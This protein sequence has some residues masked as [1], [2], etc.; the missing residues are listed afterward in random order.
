MKKRCYNC[1][2]SRYNRYGGRGIRVADCWLHDYHAFKD[3]AIS[4][5]YKKGL[6]IERIDND[7]N[8][9][10]DNC[11]WIPKNEQSKNRSMNIQVSLDGDNL[12]LKDACRKVGIIEHYA[13]IKDR[14]LIKGMS[15]KEAISVP[16]KDFKSKDIKGV[17]F[18]RLVALGFHHKSNRKEYWLCQCDCGNH[19][20]VRKDQLGKVKSCGCLKKEQDYINL[21]NGTIH[22]K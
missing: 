14:M 13:T 21:H 5:G 9:S 11:K 7:G 1:N 6:S 16:I 18:G 17:R 8:Y 15:F 12:C 4:H 3:W 10:P 20:V 2:D 19:K 22:S